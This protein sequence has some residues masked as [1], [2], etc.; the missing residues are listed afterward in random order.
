MDDGGWMMDDGRWMMNRVP[1][2]WGSGPEGRSDRAF[3]SS[4]AS[5]PKRAFFF[6][7][8][9]KPTQTRV[10]VPAGKHTV[11]AGQ[12]AIMYHADHPTLIVL[13]L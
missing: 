12:G 5:R 2:S 11:A 3:G 7:S 10:A 9:L 1:W 6:E 4:G 13:S 8:S